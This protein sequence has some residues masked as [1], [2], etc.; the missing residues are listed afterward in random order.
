MS[1]AA[2]PHTPS[3]SL[4]TFGSRHWAKPA[5]G[6]RN[7]FLAELG[8]HGGSHDAKMWEALAT[9]AATISSWRRLLQQ[10]VVGGWRCCGV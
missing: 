5:G 3:S 9:T 7:F 2:T 10:V 6:R 8:S 1:A 4:A